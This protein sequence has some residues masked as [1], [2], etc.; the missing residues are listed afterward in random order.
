MFNRFKKPVTRD[1]IIDVEKLQLIKGYLKTMIDLLKED[2]TTTTINYD[3]VSGAI[4]QIKDDPIQIQ[5][6]I[7]I[8]KVPLNTLLVNL[9]REV[10]DPV[11]RRKMME[12]IITCA[13]RL[14]EAVV[15]YISHELIIKNPGIPLSGGRR[16]RRRKT[17]RRKTR[18]R[19]NRYRR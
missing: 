10:T 2:I 3:E 13:Y 11:E 17:K 8:L 15:S 12:H 6:L 5:A 4:N 18:N 1:Y 9:Y 19:I 14:E 7:D 16:T